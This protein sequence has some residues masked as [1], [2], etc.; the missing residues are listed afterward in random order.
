[1]LTFSCLDCLENRV[2]K[3]RTVKR[4]KYFETKNEIFDMT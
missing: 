3:K 2:N 4:K 1:M